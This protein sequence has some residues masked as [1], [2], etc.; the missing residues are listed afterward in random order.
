A[1]QAGAG[2]GQG[3]ALVA[4]L[5]LALAGG[6]LAVRLAPV[7]AGRIGANALHA[8]RLGAALAAHHL[9][10]RAGAASVLGVVVVTVAVGTATTLTWSSAASA[11]AQRAAL[12]V[13]APRVLTVRAANPRQLLQA[14]RTAD[15]D[16]RS[17][18]AVVRTD[19]AAGPV[20]AVD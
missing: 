10:R 18:M 14:V 6:V 4:P 17:A 11:R 20:L 7:A 12:E 16:G 13:G 9:A 19:T 2:A 5:L 8:G 1:Y 15:P 3:V